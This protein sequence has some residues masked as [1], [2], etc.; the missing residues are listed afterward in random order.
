MAPAMRRFEQ[1]RYGVR[2]DEPRKAVF[3]VVASVGRNRHRALIL[4]TLGA[5]DPATAHLPSAI[6]FVGARREI[7]GI[8]F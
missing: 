4:I 8:D 3:H 6:S 1:Q 7:V 2:T 5:V